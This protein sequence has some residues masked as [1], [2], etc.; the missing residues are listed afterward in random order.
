MVSSCS[1]AGLDARKPLYSTE[2]HDLA[3]LF[4]TFINLFNKTY[5]GVEKFNRFL[6]FGKNV[7]EINKHNAA[8]TASA[9]YDLNEMTDWSQKEFMMR[10][11]LNP[12]SMQ[13][14]YES[15][16]VAEV[17]SVKAPASFDWRSK[18]AVT[19]VKD[20][21][22]CGSCWAFCSTA[23]I[24]NLYAI[25]YGK[26][27]YFSEQQ[28][29]DCDRR[30]SGCKGGWPAS[31]MQ[32]IMNRG[33]LIYEQKY[34]YENNDDSS[35]RFSSQNVGVK[36]SGYK[37]LKSGDENN[38][39]NYISST[40]TTWNAIDATKLQYY[41]KGVMGPSNC[42]NGVNHAVTT[43]GYGKEKNTEYWIVKNSWGKNWGE[44]GYARIQKN[45]NTCD[46][47]KHIGTAV[48]AK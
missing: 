38:M 42:G 43:V 25:K 13:R 6:S 33:G 40:S 10:A 45:K 37:S 23:N 27:E 30:S 44:Q 2:L 19:P 39:A 32:D 1:I 3:S 48:L 16:D 14:L 26:K 9:V 21:K 7:K 29:V 11:N 17:P 4:E 46:I 20:Q 24:E 31:A 41:K 5:T 8:E 36:L 15:L 28:L 34:P 12:F 22:T 35:C 18:N 47:A